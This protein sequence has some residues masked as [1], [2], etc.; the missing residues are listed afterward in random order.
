MA[1]SFIRPTNLDI[2]FGSVVYLGHIIIARRRSNIATVSPRIGTSPATL[3]LRT[4]V[5]LVV[6]LCAACSSGAPT[7]TPDVTVTQESTGPTQD[8]RA[9]EAAVDGNGVTL[10][11]RST[12]PA[13]RSSRRQ[14]SPQRELQSVSHP[15]NRFPRQRPRHCNWAAVHR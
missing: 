9:V 7:D 5:A 8:P 1:M 10:T 6:L 15:P 2:G 13:S 4:S 14:A 11:G 3:L 12:V